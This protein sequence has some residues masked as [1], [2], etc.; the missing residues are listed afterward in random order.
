[1]RSSR[2]AQ[3]PRRSRRCARRVPR[4]RRGAGRCAVEV[5]C[6]QKLE[7]VVYEQ[8][9]HVHEPQARRRIQGYARIYANDEIKSEQG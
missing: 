8:V 2:A 3:T 7:R 1:M 9:Q 4:A 5:P 6:V